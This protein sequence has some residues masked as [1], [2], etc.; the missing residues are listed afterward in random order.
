MP[1]PGEGHVEFRRTSI[2]V[3]VVA[4]NIENPHSL[5]MQEVVPSPPDCKI[6]FSVVEAHKVSNEVCA[7]FKTFMER[8]AYLEEENLALRRIINKQPPSPPK[9]QA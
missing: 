8:I 7:Q 3:R 5:S 6:P 9:D 4:I 2:H 1:Q